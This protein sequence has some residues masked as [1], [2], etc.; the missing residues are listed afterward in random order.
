MVANRNTD[1]V[2][3]N[4]LLFIHVDDTK[5]LKRGFKRKK[6][7]KSLPKGNISCRADLEL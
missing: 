6:S 7:Q 5:D 1:N 2:V 4:L 3:Y